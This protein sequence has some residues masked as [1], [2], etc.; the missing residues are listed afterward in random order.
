M[1]YRDRPAWR[2]QWWQITI[3]ALLPIVFILTAYAGERYVSNA[4]VHAVL[5][6]LAAIFVYLIA[7]V[8]YRRFSWRYTI[9]GDTVESREGVIARNVQS[10]RIQDLRNINVKQSLVQRLLRVGDVEFSSA[11]GGGVEVVFFGVEYPMR[12]KALAQRLQG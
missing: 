10:I 3:A 11:G 6:M 2:N 5:V 4:T 8:V 9:D 1:H 12:V 7:V